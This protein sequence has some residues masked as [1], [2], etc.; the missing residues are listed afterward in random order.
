MKEKTVIIEG[1]EVWSEDLSEMT[2]Y[3][4]TDAVTKLGPS[5]RLPTSKEFKEILYPNRD[6][7]PGKVD[8]YSYYWSSTEFD[9]F[10]AWTF[11]FTNGSASYYYKFTTNYVRAVRDLT[12]DVAIEYLLKDF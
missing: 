11:Y 6:N 8:M 3:E 5:W 4:A 12:G 10:T 9:N 7:L 2:W 1:L